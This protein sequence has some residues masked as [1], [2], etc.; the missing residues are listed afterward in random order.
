[1][2]MEH[3]DRMRTLWGSFYE[4]WTDCQQVWDDEV[5]DRFHRDFIAPLDTDIQTI[6]QEAEHLE[7]AV[8]SVT[9]YLR[10]SGD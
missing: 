1:M 7:Q 9:Q 8:Q 5:A 3:I 6:L 2:S 10:Y 4:Q